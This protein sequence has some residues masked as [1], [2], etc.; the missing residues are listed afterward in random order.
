MGWRDQHSWRR[1]ACDRDASAERRQEL[2][3]CDRYP[4][5]ECES[6]SVDQNCNRWRFGRVFHSRC[7]WRPNVYRQTLRRWSNDI[8]RFHT[9][10]GQIPFQTRKKQ[11]I[12]SIPT[13]LEI[14]KFLCSAPAVL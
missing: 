10:P 13:E 5:A 9:R 11:D 12:G 8:G 1:L 7:S 6:H 4:D 14:V 2:E 3:W